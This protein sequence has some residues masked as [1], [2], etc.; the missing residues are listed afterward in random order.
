MTYTCTVCG[1]KDTKSIQPTG[2]HTWDAGEVTTEPTC[3][4]EG[5]MTYTCTVCGAKDTKSIQPTEHTW[6]RAW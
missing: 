4:A 3:S 2:E 1:A 5:V 6:M